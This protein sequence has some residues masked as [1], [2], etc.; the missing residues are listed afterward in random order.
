MLFEPPLSYRGLGQLT[1]AQAHTH[2][3]SVVL[4]CHAASSLLSSSADNSMCL[5]VAQSLLLC[6]LLGVRRLQ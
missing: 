5:E 3:F 4:F 6:L 1:R 2:F